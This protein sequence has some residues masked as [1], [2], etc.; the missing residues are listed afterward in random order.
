MPF[1]FHY[2]QSLKQFL[3][4]FEISLEGVAEQRLAESARSSQKDISV[5]A[6]KIVHHVS[7]VNIQQSLLPNMLELVSIYRV[8]ESTHFY[9]L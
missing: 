1:Q 4:P 9:P 6:G 5:L 8:S 3:L 2:L 7:L